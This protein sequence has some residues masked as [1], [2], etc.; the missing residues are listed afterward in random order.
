M[1]EHIMRETHW[2]IKDKSKNRF[3]MIFYWIK[4]RCEY[5]YERYRELYWGKWVKNQRKTFEDFRDDMYES[6]LKHCAEFWE[7][8][9]SID[10]I[11]SDGDYCKENCRWATPELQTL[12]RS[13]TRTILIDGKE[14]NAFTLAEECSIPNDTASWRI[15]AYLKWKITKEWL[16]A[17][18]KIDQRN[19]VEIDWITYYNKDIERITGVNSWNARRRLRMYQK[20]E[21]TKEQLLA[22]RRNYPN[23]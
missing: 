22:P 11:D 12:N 15:T 1:L 8:N 16:L 3:Y 23:R 6:Y 2:F 21:L 13:K 7:E 20:W 18:G 10:R 5:R 19:Y 14:Y 17:K 4:T 9:T